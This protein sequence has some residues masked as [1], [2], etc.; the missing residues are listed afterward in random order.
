MSLMVNRRRG[1][2][3]MLALALVAASCANGDESQAEAPSADTS[4]LS[5][6]ERCEANAEAGTIIFV[7]SFDFAAAASILDVVVAEAEGDVQAERRAV[8]RIRIK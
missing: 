3:V 8:E 6:E 2:M 1:W 4:S 7:S 5:A